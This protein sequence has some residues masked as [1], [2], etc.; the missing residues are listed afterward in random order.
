MVRA[1]L[2]TPCQIQEYI[3]AY[4]YLDSSFVHRITPET[5][6]YYFALNFFQTL[7]SALFYYC[8]ALPYFENLR[9]WSVVKIRMTFNRNLECVFSCS[10]HTTGEKKGVIKSD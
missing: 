3:L 7:F 9:M 6:R 1:L 8:F 4:I 2:R 10:F 5:L